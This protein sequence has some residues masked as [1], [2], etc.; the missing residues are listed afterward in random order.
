MKIG[1]SFRQGFDAPGMP[2]PSVMEKGQSAEE[3]SAVLSSSG[4]GKRPPLH[5]SRSLLAEI[6]KT[7]IESAGPLTPEQ[8]KYL[9]QHFS[10]PMAT[11][12]STEHFGIGGRVMPDSKG[13]ITHL[14]LQYGNVEFDKPLPEKTKHALLGVY[15]TLFTN[16]HPTTQFTIV[17]ANESGVN[18]LSRAVQESGMANPERVNI[19]NG[20]AEKGFSIWIRDSMIPVASPD[21]LTK[22]LIQDRTYWPGPEDAKI[23]MLI[24]ESSDAVSSQ[25]HQPLRIDGGNLLS[26]EEYILVGHDSVAQTTARLK[27]L[28][29]DPEWE[30]EIIHFYEAKTGNEVVGPGQPA[31]EGQVTLDE[32]WKGIA[33][34]VFHS[35]FQRKIFV[36]CNDDPS[37]PLVEEQPVF[38]IDMAVT[39][40]GND[41]FL[42]GDPGMAIQVLQSLSPEEKAAVNSKMAQ[43]AGFSDNPDLIGK[44]IEVNGSEAHQA[45]FDNVAREL[46]GR[47]Y[48]I[49][50][51]PCLIGLRTTWSLPYLTYN[52]CIQEN[53]TDE[54]GTQVKKVYLP[55]YGCEPLEQIARAKYEQLGYEVVPLSMAA[56]SILE[57]AIRCSSYPLSRTDVPAPA[58]EK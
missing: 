1:D 27:E 41:T 56:V 3:D 5:L 34:E 8:K 30:N 21:D 9:S 57:G 18:D 50:R 49:H 33:P 43:E 16:L 38:H 6:A 23:P 52:N 19:V 46:E 47:G 48:T 35:E 45:N 4:G 44:L 40:V 7:G 39:P 53:Y 36:I 32:M 2:A 20:K 10:A 26:N 51:I 31:G 42:V 15:K 25:I 22:L 12:E 37:T 58:M 24:D 55:V 17:A 13:R 28:A 11:I 29:A 54:S 14:A